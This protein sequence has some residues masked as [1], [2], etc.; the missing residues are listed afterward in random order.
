MNNNFL[1]KSKKKIAVI[2]LAVTLFT[3]VGPSVAFAIPVVVVA[4][5]SL[6][7]IKRTIDS[8]LQQ[9]KS[10]VL[11][12]L[13]WTF[14][15]ILL[16]QITASVVNWINSGFQ[17]NPSFL[18]NPERFF[19]DVGDQIT[20]D[21]IANT[22]VLSGLCTPFNIDIRLALALGQSRQHP[23]Y[24]CTLGS[25]IQNVQNSTINGYSIGGFMG[26][27]FRQGG[28]PAFITMTTD[29]QNNA[30]GAY[31]TAQSDLLQRIGVTEDR[32]KQDLIQGGGFL[33]WKKCSDVSTDDMASQR[34][35]DEGMG[36]DYSALN[37]S[38]N[39]SVGMGKDVYTGGN[40]SVDKKVDKKTGTVTYRNCETQTP[41]SVIGGSVN[42]ALGIPQDTLNLADSINEIV[43]ALMTQLVSQV[44][45]GGLRG[46]SGSGGGGNLPGIAQRLAQQ[47]EEEQLTSPKLSLRN[48]IIGYY[49]E[50]ALYR[51]IYAEA[52]SSIAV[53][54]Q[55]YSDARSCFESKINP[56]GQSSS[57]YA[58]DANYARTQIAA[59]DTA[60]AAKVAPLER[61][62][63]DR[64]GG[65][66]ARL[67]ATG[68]LLAD[69]DKANTVSSLS[70]VSERFKTAIEGGS[71][72]QRNASS[73]TAFVTPMDT[74][75]A[76][77]DS[78][79][80]R[81]ALVPLTEEAAR[82]GQ[83]CAA[84]LGNLGL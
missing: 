46:A 26:G 9:V 11:D 21:F 72:V 37:K 59:I 7:S 70:A 77:E 58:Y 62:Y 52:S 24:S 22:G 19:L 83:A 20:G 10:Y 13:A 15:K 82:F 8:T 68:K 14:A 45:T 48:S 51:Q 18:T 16:Q 79:S 64:L 54:R 63:G 12:T 80:L 81:N 60:L 73:T 78:E 32:Q 67:A 36:A 17:G 56:L 28:W 66:E 57:Q 25:V 44:L 65:A 76:Q 40:L 43:G 4:D 50:A 42:K 34:D 69:I 61:V 75:Y 6:T 30:I 2:L 3:Q 35:F 53:T 27:D 1:E 29:P 31:I 5:T 47:S 41:G 23:R 38:G 39:Q 71:Q 74:Q 84:P 33:S 49:D 55:R